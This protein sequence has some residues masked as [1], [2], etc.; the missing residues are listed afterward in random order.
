[1]LILKSLPGSGEITR[2][3]KNIWQ[4]LKYLKSIRFNVHIQKKLL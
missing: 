2:V 1:M 3:Y 4:Y